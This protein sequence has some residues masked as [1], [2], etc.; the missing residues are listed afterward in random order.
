MLKIP[1]T[2][3]TVSWPVSHPTVLADRQMGTQ[4]RRVSRPVS[5]FFY[6]VKIIQQVSHQLNNG[7]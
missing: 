4:S 5:I 2:V 7:F 3:K 6:M 1:V